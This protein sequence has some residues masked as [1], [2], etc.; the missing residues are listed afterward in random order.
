M[1]CKYGYPDLEYSM[2]TLGPTDKLRMP[3]KDGV[4]SQ[5]SHGW[6]RGT[7]KVSGCNTPCLGAQ[8]AL[9]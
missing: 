5:M 9:E 4:E 2:A 8:A 1:A 7:P 3:D 6:G